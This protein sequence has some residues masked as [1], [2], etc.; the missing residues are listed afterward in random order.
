MAQTILKIKNTN[1][2]SIRW[3]QLANWHMHCYQLHTGTEDLCIPASYD[4]IYGSNGMCLTPAVGHYRNR[5]CPIKFKYLISLLFALSK[6]VQSC[7]YWILSN[8]ECRGICCLIVIRISNKWIQTNYCLHFTDGNACMCN[9]Q[10]FQR[11]FI[12]FGGPCGV[13]LFH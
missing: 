1:L 3:C 6:C 11:M 12:F 7:I 13:P 4:S 8:D 10:G 5:H 2:S 9:V